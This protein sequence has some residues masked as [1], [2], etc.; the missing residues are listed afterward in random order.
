MTDTLWDLSPGIFLLQLNLIIDKEKYVQSLPTRDK[1][2][3]LVK[4]TNSIESH[5]WNVKHY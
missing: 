1:Y 4:E 3:Y 2:K 5:L